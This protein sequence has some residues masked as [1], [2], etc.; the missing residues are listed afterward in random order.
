MQSTSTMEVF[1]ITP[2]RPMIPIIAIKLSDLF[3]IKNP[4]ITPINPNGIENK[5]TTGLIVLLNIKAIIAK[6]PKKAIM[7][8]LA[9]KILPRLVHNTLL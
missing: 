6:I 2:A 1:T 4:K 8:A 7:P 3:E 5:I 9:R